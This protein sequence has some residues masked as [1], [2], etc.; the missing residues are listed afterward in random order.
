MHV[1]HQKGKEGPLIKQVTTPIQQ[2]FLFV[3]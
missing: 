2:E 1:K 3:C